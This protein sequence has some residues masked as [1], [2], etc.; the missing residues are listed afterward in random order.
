M[1]N[2]LPSTVAVAMQILNDFKPVVT[3]TVKQVALGTAFA[4]DGKKK[5]SN[6]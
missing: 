4:Q 3:E 5:Q 1:E 6:G 2:V